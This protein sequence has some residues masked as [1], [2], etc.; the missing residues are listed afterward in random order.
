MSTGSKR[1]WV[2]FL[3]A[4]GAV[5]GSRG[6]M[7]VKLFRPK[8]AEKLKL[9]HPDLSRV[10]Y[11]AAALGAKFIVIETQ[12]GRA[13]QEKARRTGH[14]NA[15]FGQSPHNFNPALAVDIGPHNYPG[16]L[17]DY[18]DL[19]I[20]M[21]AAAKEEGIGIEWGGDW[22][23]LKDWP[24]FQLLNWKAKKKNLAP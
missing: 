18:H 19:A 15:H 1:E 12:R 21:F 16:K 2:E 9:L 6:R 13:A 5:S 14:S 3:Y 24:H 11:K 8:D 22:K 17:G 20:A 4:P 23:T 10:I 7:P